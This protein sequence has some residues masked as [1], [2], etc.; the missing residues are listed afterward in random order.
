M[1]KGSKYTVLI[2]DDE[3]SSR[4][5]LS[6]FV[7]KYCKR[8]EIIGTAENILEAKEIIDNEN[9]DLL[10]LDIEMPHGNAFDLLDLFEEIPFQVI[11]ITAFS[12]Y[13]IQAFNLSNASYLL[14]PVDIEELIS[15]VNRTCDNLDQSIKWQ[16]T[17]Q[18]LEGIK[19][20][21]LTK[22]VIPLIDGFRVIETQ[23]VI[24][25]Q[26]ADNFSTLFLS[27]NQK[28]MAC[29]NLKFYEENLSSSGFLRIHR[30]TLIN[31]DHVRQYNKGSGGIVTMSNGK[32][33]DVAASRKRGF[34][35][36]FSG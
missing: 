15:A 6:A 18:L 20:K 21:Q 16:H 33:L 23:D 35:K 14:K 22:I 29:R 4:K 13:A 9:P 11:F 12:Q 31:I 36:H 27:N 1:S 19:E 24:Y 26:A 2:V 5:S 7:N 8:L 17:A 28:E 10:L 30:S 34:L 32:E 25:I 3:A